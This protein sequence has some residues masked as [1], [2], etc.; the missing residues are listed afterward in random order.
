MKNF[1]KRTLRS[2]RSHPFVPVSPLKLKLEL[3]LTLTLP[4][5]KTF[6]LTTIF[7]YKVEV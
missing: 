7:S 5:T 1:E 2:L 6:S 3:E 4:L